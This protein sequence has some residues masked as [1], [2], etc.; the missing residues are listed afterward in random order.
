MR[1]R[2]IE[3]CHDAQYLGSKIRFGLPPHN[4]S[5]C[6][7]SLVCPQYVGA[8]KLCMVRVAVVSQSSKVSVECKQCTLPRIQT[9]INSGRFSNPPW[10]AVVEYNYLLHAIGAPSINGP[11]R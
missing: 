8:Q 7:E 9:L 10:H 1:Y 4:N 2:D 3:I 6:R 11:V 5:Q